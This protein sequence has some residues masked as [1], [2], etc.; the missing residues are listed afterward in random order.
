MM[1]RWAKAVD[2][3]DTSRAYREG[4]LA[5]SLG[6]VFITDWFNAKAAL[7]AKGWHYDPLRHEWRHKP[8]HPPSWGK[9]APMPE[10]EAS[11]RD[12]TCP[13]G[14]CA[15]CTA[16]IHHCVCDPAPRPF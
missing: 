3:L 8:D 15:A 9:L 6:V 2:S 7:R 16:M 11:E 13:L 12:Y 5:A 4:S 10:P 14:H 1:Q